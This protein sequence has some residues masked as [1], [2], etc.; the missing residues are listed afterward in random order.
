V[1]N[2]G[3]GGP[4]VGELLAA[5]ENDRGGPPNRTDE[6]ISGGLNKS[7]VLFETLPEVQ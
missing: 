7:V 2:S 1:R 6:A 5:Q 4:D 3:T